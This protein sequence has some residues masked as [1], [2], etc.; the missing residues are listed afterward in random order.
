MTISVI[1][2]V[3]NSSDAKVRFTKLVGGTSGS[4]FMLPSSRHDILST[5]R[6]TNIA[7][8]HGRRIEKIE[9]EYANRQGS[10]QTESIGNDD[11]NW[12]YINLDED[13]FI[14]YITGR[15]GTL[16]DQITFYTSKR[17]IFGPFGGA[18]GNA[19]EI[20]IPSNAKVIGFYGKEGPSIHQ[21]G[22]I[23]KT[24]AR[25]KRGPK[26]RRAVV[27]DHRKKDRVVRDHRKKAPIVRDHRKK[28]PVVRD[29][30]KK[31]R[32]VRDQRNKGTSLISR[33]IKKKD[34]GIKKEL[35][36]LQRV[37]KVSTSPNA[38]SSLL[39]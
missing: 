31:K 30:R 15:S 32:V 3:I 10:K 1:L 7:I 34:K 35:H 29:H 9:V 20:N 8:Q 21:I 28:N 24:S 2:L 36:K 16:I 22:L 38:M 19:F 13:E 25:V 4:K 26:R 23:Y 14:V 39:R 11:G 5:Y 6:I 37:F 17:R 12:S 33:K 27:R 18:G